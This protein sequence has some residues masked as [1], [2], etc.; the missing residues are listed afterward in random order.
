MRGIREDMKANWSRY[1][2]CGLLWA[3][4]RMYLLTDV[5]VRHTFNPF[6][7]LSGLNAPRARS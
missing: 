6:E 1:V 2:L 3:V 4:D 7:A 5:G